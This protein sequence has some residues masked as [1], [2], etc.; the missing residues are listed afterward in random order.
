[1]TKVTE[2]VIE[3]GNRLRKVKSLGQKE[4]STVFT[5]Y[6]LSKVVGAIDAACADIDSMPMM[7]Q[8]PSSEQGDVG[9]ADEPV[10]D[11]REELRLERE[12]FTLEDAMAYLRDDT[13]A[14]SS[15]FVGVGAGI[16][17]IGTFKTRRFKP[18]WSAE[19][20]PTQQEMWKYL[21]DVMCLGNFFELDPAL[22]PWVFLPV[23]TLLCTDFSTA[24]KQLGDK[25]STGWMFVAAVKQVLAMPKLPQ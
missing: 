25:G 1:M 11:A 6:A 15:A 13:A 9:A 2:Y 21:T 14:F 17:A 20:L 3:E 22:I 5:P 12:S 24:G 10:F 16:G 19:V 4:P 18:K 8:R 23:I 7:A